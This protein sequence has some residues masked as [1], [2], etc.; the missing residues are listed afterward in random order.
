MQLSIVW[1]TGARKIGRSINLSRFYIFTLNFLINTLPIITSISETFA[2][3][4]YTVMISSLV[5]FGKSDQINYWHVHWKGA[6]E[7][8]AHLFFQAGQR[9]VRSRKT[10]PDYIWEKSTARR[11][12]KEFRKTLEMISYRVSNSGLCFEIATIAQLHQFA[13]FALETKWLRLNAM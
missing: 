12:M 13:C 6:S 1:G 3:N 5:C 4:P 2:K 9:T 8:P 10:L 7:P 11:F